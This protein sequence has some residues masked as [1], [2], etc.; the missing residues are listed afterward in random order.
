MKY[1]EIRSGFSIRVD[2][3]E[4][5]EYSDQLT[6]KIHTLT[7]V[8]E[9]NFPYDVIIS[10]LEDDRKEVETVKLEPQAMNAL[11]SLGHHFAG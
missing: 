1:L 7:S 8:Y 10:L 3:I 9:A 2:S 11:N 6:S 4:A 5:I